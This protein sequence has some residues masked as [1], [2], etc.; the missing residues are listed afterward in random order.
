MSC[1]KLLKC[2]ALLTMCPR[3]RPSWTM[4]ARLTIERKST[5]KLLTFVEWHR[6]ESTISFLQLAIL[7]CSFVVRMIHQILSSPTTSRTGDRRAVKCHFDIIRPI[8]WIMSLMLPVRVMHSVRDSFRECSGA[9]PSRFVYQSDWRRRSRPSTRKRRFP[10][11]F[12]TTIIP[13]GAR[14]RLLIAFCD[15]NNCLP[16]WERAEAERRLILSVTSIHV[17]A[18]STDMSR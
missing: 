14:K 2:L 15:K 4:F 11:T 5:E 13:A 3:H 6:I 12:S 17:F 1:A 16:S 8:D 7:E 9:D 10:Q 18:P